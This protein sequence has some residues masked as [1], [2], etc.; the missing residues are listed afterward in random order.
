[1][2]AK[3]DSEIVGPVVPGGPSISGQPELVSVDVIPSKK[4][5]LTGVSNKVPVLVKIVS[6]ALPQEQK[7]DRV[8]LNL[9]MVLDR[10]GSMNSNAKLENSKKAVIKVLENLHPE[11]IVHFVCYGSRV[12]TIFENKNPKN[13]AELTKMVEAI[14]TEGMTNLSGGLEEG[15]RLL[16]KYQKKGFS[17][18]MF[19]FSDGLANEGITKVDGIT[20]IVTKL[21]DNNKIKVDSFGIGDDFDSEI[22]KNIAEYGS[23]SFFFIDSSDEIPVL[24]GKALEGLL[25]LVGENCI[26]KVRGT[27]CGIVKQ[28]YGK[29]SAVLIDGANLGD[30]HQSNTRT[31][32]VELEVSPKEAGEYGVMIWEVSYIYNNKT[33]THNGTLNLTVTSSNK[34]FK[35][36]TENE[37]VQVAVAVQQAAESDEKI[38]KFIKQGRAK[39]ALME[40]KAQC[41]SLESWAKIDKSEMMSNLLFNAK[42]TEALIQS[43]GCSKRANMKMIHNA[44][45][46]RR[47]SVKFASHYADD[48]F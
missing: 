13:K 8:P 11:D 39:E 37:E 32:L 38:H 20:G 22:M 46:K 2:E 19:L 28:I 33:I 47:G 29:S 21:K 10:S 12:T 16:A 48:V 45:G 30:L 4:V 31:Q 9:C 18:R 3:D 23:G 17:N 24:V 34:E 15:G 26:L 41:A 7:K 36:A 6:D 27:G 1:M 44:Y 40:Q 35:K 42:K 43:E 14:R 5:A 25:E